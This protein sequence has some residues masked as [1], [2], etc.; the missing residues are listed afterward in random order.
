MNACNGRQGYRKISVTIIGCGDAFINRYWPYLQRLVN[1]DKI[2]LT[3]VE[4]EP[5]SDLI[6]RKV[7]LAEES[8]EEYNAKKLSDNYKEFSVMCDSENGKIVYL[9]IENSSDKRLR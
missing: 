3:V 5:L 2:K 4:N 7:T 9:N 1:L 6:T 8:G